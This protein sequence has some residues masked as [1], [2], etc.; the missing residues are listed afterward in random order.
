MSKSGFR[1]AKVSEKT[2]T[3]EAEH[4]ASQSL[5]M[6][7]PGSPFVVWSSTGR[8]GEVGML[9]G[10]SFMELD[11]FG[12]IFFSMQVRL[13]GVEHMYMVNEFGE[14]VMSLLANSR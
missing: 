6:R 3:D 2:L 14:L 1:D 11:M 12:V 4:K 10:A 9:N 13:A 5:G 7:W 8:P